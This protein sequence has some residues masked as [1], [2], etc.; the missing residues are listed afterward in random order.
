MGETVQGYRIECIENGVL[1]HFNDDG[2][3]K[4]MFSPSIWG[5]RNFI[6]TGEP[7]EVIDKPYCDELLKER[8]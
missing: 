5:I 8:R 7:V 1:I 2:K 4:I 3:D 6:R